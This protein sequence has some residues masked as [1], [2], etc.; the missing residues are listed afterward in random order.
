MIPDS[1]SRLSSSINSVEVGGV[2]GSISNPGPPPDDATAVAVNRVVIPN[3]TTAT[4][5]IA[6]RNMLD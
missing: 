5:A 2:I 3:P 6:F 1:S 4:D